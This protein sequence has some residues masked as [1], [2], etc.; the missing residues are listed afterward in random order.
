MAGLDH[1][2]H[3]LEQALQVDAHQRGRHEAEDRQRGVAAADRGLAL[4]DA[5]E[6]AL[7]GERLELGAGIGDRRE[8]LAAL[9]GL[10]PEVVE[11]AARLERRAR[12]G[13]GDEERRVE[14]ER[15]GGVAQA[16]GCV[17]SSTWKPG[18]SKVRL[19]T[20][21][22]RLDPPIPSRTKVSMI[23]G[24]ARSSTNRSRSAMRLRMRIGSSSQPSHFA[25]SCPV[26]SVASRAQMRSTTS[27]GATALTA[28]TGGTEARAGRTHGA[29][30]AGH[31]RGVRDR[32]APSVGELALEPVGDLVHV[33]DVLLA[34][35]DERRSVDLAHPLRQVAHERLFLG[36]LPDGQLELVGAPLHLGD[37]RSHVRVDVFGL[38]PRAVDPG[39]Q[40]H[41]DRSI[42]VSP[43][44]GLHLRLVRRVHLRRPVVAGEAGAH[45]HESL[46]QLRA[47]NRN[48]ERDA[49]SHRDADER[50]LLHALLL[51]QLDQI[52]GVRVAPRPDRRAPE[53]A[54]VV[55][56]H[57]MRGPERLPLRVPHPAVADPRVDEDDRRAVAG[58]LDVQ[59]RGR[60]VQAETSSPRLP[61][62]PS[63]SSAKESENFCTPSF[64]STATTSS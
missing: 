38:P 15:L 22:A 49:A 39:A 28:P 33:R 32:R 19:I 56:E 7:A 55:A 6:V 29:L 12:L 58:G 62:T 59:I 10:V 41:L 26:Q 23:P 25:S 13:G 47:S 53:A 52:A 30:E 42:D 61:R 48:L 64:S 51:E 17:V 14:V 16:A 8:E 63:S 60:D 1:L 5:D 3:A 40:A 24:A 21:G 4:E 45:E 27:A 57:A 43:L 36:R 54:Q 2:F 20:S 50:R 11:V 34:D 18:A 37:A 46:D 9:A 44:E 31:V 35:Q